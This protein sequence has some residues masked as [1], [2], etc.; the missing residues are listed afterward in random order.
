MHIFDID[1][2][3]Y[4]NFEYLK[5]FLIVWIKE[6][7]KDAFDGL[8]S[9]VWKLSFM[10]LIN[11][12]GTLILPFLTLYTTQELGWTT[13]QG[14]IAASC[15]GFGSLAGAYLGGVMTDR[16]GYFRTM[17]YGL[18]VAGVLFFMTQYILSFYMLCAALFIS[19]IFIY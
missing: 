5:K 1:F 17:S 3:N 10:M 4:P 13:A 19:S 18:L 11:R 12:M 8:N 6:L 9:D 14:G 7:Y 2:R 15:F 16:I